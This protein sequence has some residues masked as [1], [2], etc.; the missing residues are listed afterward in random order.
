MRT[1]LL[2][3]LFCLGALVVLARECTPHELSAVE[4]PAGV[5]ADSAAARIVI[6]AIERAGGY[7]A[8]RQIDSIAYRKRTILYR[9][10]GTVESERVQWHRYRLGAQPRYRIE[11]REGDTSWTMV[12]GADTCAHFAERL[13]R[14][15]DTAAFRQMVATALYTLFMPFKLLDPG[16]RLRYLG[17][18]TLPDGRPAEVVEATYADAPNVTTRERWTYWFDS[19]T[20]DYLAAWVDH[21]PADALILND[22]YVQAGPLRFNAV[23][24]SWRTDSLGRPQYVRGKF[25]YDEFFVGGS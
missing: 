15:C 24:T 22:R 7:E 25:F 18:D 19:T 21:G 3:Y 8:F 23:R 11:W 5:E 14:P 10:D 13:T 2:P 12:Y 6:R 1:R 16:T 4:L 20:F 9:P 17:R